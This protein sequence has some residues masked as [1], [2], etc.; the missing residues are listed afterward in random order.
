[1]Y[2]SVR[3]FARLGRVFPG[4]RTRSVLWVAAILLLIAG[5]VLFE[6]ATGITPYVRDQGVAALNARFASQVELASLQVSLFPR[7]AILG[8]GLTLRHNGRTDVPPLLTVPSF[9]ASAGLLGLRDTPLRLNTIELEGLDIRIP[10]GGMNRRQGQAALEDV[11]PMTPPPARPAASRTPSPRLLI[12]RLVS[13]AATLEIASNDPAK[14]P[15]R[16]EIRDLEMLG[17]GEASGSS[18]RASLTNPKPH[19]LIDAEGTFGPWQSEEPRLTPIRG[20]YLFGSANLDT[21]K[22]I[23][24]TLS[25][26]GSYQGVLE[27]I[28]VSGHTETPDFVIDLAGQPVPLTTRFEAVVDGTNGNTW[29]ERVEPGFA[30]PPSSPAAPSSARARSRAAIS[31]LT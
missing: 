27:R 17:L 25:S 15:R 30:T 10:P 19:G 5:A 11:S 22:G 21:I 4:M 23:G 7:P 8:E 3:R 20:A 18:F 16:F 6:M 26:A 28:A 24:G 31:R 2:L 13:R 14:L 9:A 29:L 1:M 12:D